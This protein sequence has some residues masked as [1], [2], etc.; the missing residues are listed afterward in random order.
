MTYFY[1]NNLVLSQEN[2]N[3]EKLDISSYG[4]YTL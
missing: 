2:R 1:H 4:L 3:E